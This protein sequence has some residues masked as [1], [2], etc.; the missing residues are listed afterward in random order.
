MSQGVQG[1]SSRA[2]KGAYGVST[3]LYL[4]LGALLAVGVLFVFLTGVGLGLAF[5]QGCVSFIEAI[6]LF[7]VGFFCGISV[8]IAGT[9]WI[10]VLM[11]AF[12]FGALCVSVVSLEHHSSPEAVPSPMLVG[13]LVQQRR[14]HR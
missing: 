3:I 10:V 5:A 14:T 11:V 7:V 12:W 8:L 1:W 9:W 6:M 13:W 2:W 4:V